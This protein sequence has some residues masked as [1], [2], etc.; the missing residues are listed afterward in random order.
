MKRVV[1]VSLGSARRD[2]QIKLELLGETVLIERLGTDGSI[3]EAEKLLKK[4]DG[5]VDVLALGG[6]NIHLQVGSRLYPL[7][8]GQRLARAVR[9]TPVVDGSG[10]KNTVEPQTVID[11]QKRY[12]WPQKGQR[13]LMVSALDRWCLAEALAGAGCRLIIGDAVFALSIPMPFYSLKTFALAARLT[14]PLLAKLP[15]KALYPLGKKQETSHSRWERIYEQADIIAGDFHF[16]RRHMPASLPGKNIITSTVTREDREF[17]RRRGIKY[18]VTTCPN[19][20]GRSF[21]ANIL[22]AVCVA[23]LKKPFSEIKPH[24]FLPMMKKIEWQPSVE[25]LN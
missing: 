3:D 9:N 2:Q 5:Q 8:D 12:G 21:G 22:E 24:M 19:L 11:L 16:I 4:L 13:V 7:R 17:L 18:L 20:Q 10:I 1:S 14:L 6:V 23:L 15:I 25:K